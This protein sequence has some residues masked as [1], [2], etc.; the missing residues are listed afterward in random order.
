MAQKNKPKP[1]NTILALDAATV[2]TGY[3]VVTRD[4]I[5]KD[6]GLIHSPASRPTQRRLKDLYDALVDILDKYKV[7]GIAVED[8][9]LGSN[10]STIKALSW[11]RGIIMLLAEQREKEL[12]V[13]N[14]KTA[15]KRAKKGNASKAE[16][17]AAIAEKLKLEGDLP[18][19][20]S[21]AI[22]IGLAFF[23]QEGE[24]T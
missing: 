11:A 23:L 20:V 15:K 14:N 6:K 1:I 9:F 19:D 7:D 18:E 16:V 13:I 4:L 12:I 22:A 2:N 24:P 3:A 17:K 21:D 5:I 10:V 8:Q